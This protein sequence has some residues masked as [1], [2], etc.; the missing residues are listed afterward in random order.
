MKVCLCV[1]ICLFLCLCAM[2]IIHP[3]LWQ[4][5]FI[6]LHCMWF[7][8]FIKIRTFCSYNTLCS[9]TYCTRNICTSKCGIYVRLYIVYDAC[10]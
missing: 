9:H 4:T 1:F 7:V 8:A 2:N 6:Q 5:T 3:A 10:E